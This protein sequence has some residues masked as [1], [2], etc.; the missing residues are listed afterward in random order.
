MGGGVVGVGGLGGGGGGLRG[1]ERPFHSPEWSRPM[2]GKGSPVRVEKV[3]ITSW[4]LL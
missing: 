1:K 4:D 2:R 3:P